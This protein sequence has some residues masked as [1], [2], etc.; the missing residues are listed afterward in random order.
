MFLNYYETFYGNSYDWHKVLQTGD[1]HECFGFHENSFFFQMFKKLIDRLIDTGV[2]QYLNEN[3][4]RRKLKF[5]KVETEPAILTVQDLAFG[6]NIWLGSCL[7]SF[8]SFLVENIRR[9]KKKWKKIRR[10]GKEIKGYKTKKG[11][12]VN[13]TKSSINCKKTPDS[14]KVERRQ[15]ESDS[16][17]VKKPIVL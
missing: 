17:A 8:L 13:T 11:A 15:P 1:M 10:L 2:M 6:F 14:K 12:A 4:Y 7:V 5:R 3:F 9:L 16:T